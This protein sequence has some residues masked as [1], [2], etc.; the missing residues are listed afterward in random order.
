M[1]K[2]I[3]KCL[4]DYPAHKFRIAFRSSVMCISIQVHNILLG[5][6]LESRDTIL[7]HM[8]HVL[9]Y[10]SSLFKQRFRKCDKNN[11]SNSSK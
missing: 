1:A 4:N 7:V 9:V 2:N 10:R 8:N 3:F 6:R 5:I 11:D